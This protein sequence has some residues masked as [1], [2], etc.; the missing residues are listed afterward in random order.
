MPMHPWGYAADNGGFWPISLEIRP[1]TNRFVLY[2]E[3]IV[4]QTERG[5]R[6]T[7]FRMPIRAHAD[8]RAHLHQS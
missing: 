8:S 5:H 4:T 1:H 6:E 3:K 2:S 7:R